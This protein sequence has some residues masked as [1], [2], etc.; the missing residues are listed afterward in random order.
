MKES[1]RSNLLYGV[2]EHPPMKKKIPLA[3]QHV[4][5]MF[6][7][8]VLVP[9]LVNQLAGTEV[10]S[11]P[12]AI[13]M[14]GVG[15][16]I[17]QI[18]TGGTSPVYLGSSFA[19]ISPIAL[20]YQAGGMAGA[21]T[22][23]VLVGL[24]YIIFAGAVARAGK[25][26]IDRF[27]PPV[28][29]GPTIL[30]IGLNL[31]SSAIGQIGISSGMETDWRNLVV[32]L[33]TLGSAIVFM[34]FAK[35]FLNIIPFLMAIVMGYLAAIM[36]GMVDFTP[37]KEA[38]W[39]SVPK[40]QVM[41]WDYR[42]DLMVAI[43]LAPVALVTIPEHIGDHKALSTIIDQDLLKKPGL[44]RTLLGD[45]LATLVAA[46]VGAP[47]NTT[48]GENTAV[49]GM[50]KIASVAVLRLAAI[51]AICMAFLGKVM[52]LISTIPNPVLGGVSVLLYGFIGLNGVKVWIEH[53]L[54]LGF[55]R[56]IV[57]A[58][59]MLVFGLGGA[60]ISHQLGGMTFALSGMSLAVVLGI[61]L[62]QILPVTQEEREQQAT[63]EKDRVRLKFLH[64]N[65]ECM[66][67]VDRQMVETL[68]GTQ[69]GE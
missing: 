58:S 38:A 4:F 15:T 6:G 29:V 61:I 23:L 41:F 25:D 19:F 36:L 40:F 47:A 13:M 26:W 46:L 12:V 39:F 50:T 21:M 18:C 43:Q 14:S 53:R 33:V 69:E 66:E 54:D 57:I 67:Y 7:A 64:E 63:W 8:T 27:L 59:V 60:A 68:A 52:A 16:L 3:L 65:P 9:I 45:G 62:N 17:Y 56:N 34:V 1:P 55:A 44:A 48:Y 37:V 2:S 28:V 31:A 32:A 11:T 5:A 22:G 30:I 51:M 49:V 20:A 42:P 24:I 35:G 10:L